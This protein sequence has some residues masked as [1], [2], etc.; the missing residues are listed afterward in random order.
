MEAGIIDHELGRHTSRNAGLAHIA[1]GADLVLLGSA[2]KS[3]G[4][5]AVATV[6]S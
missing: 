3:R 5:G 1:L 4:D 6:A 2:L